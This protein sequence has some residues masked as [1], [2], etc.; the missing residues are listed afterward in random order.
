MSVG[1]RTNDILRQHLY[2][3]MRITVDFKPSKLSPSTVA[4]LAEKWLPGLP[5]GGLSGKS[6]RYEDCVVS[7]DPR[8]NIEGFQSQFTANH[9]LI[10]YTAW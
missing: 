7:S 3:G 2:R 1:E 5:R 10:A 8:N 6:L 4:C 9:S